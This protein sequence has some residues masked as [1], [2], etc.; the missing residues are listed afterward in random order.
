MQM[1]IPD[2]MKVPDKMKKPMVI[3]LVA[4]VILFGGI[5]IYKVFINLMMKRFF[6]TQKN[7]TYTVSTTAANYAIWKPQIS[8]VGSTRAT[9]GVNVTAQIGGMIQKIYFTPGAI[10]DA[11]DTL[12]QQNADPNIGQLHSLQANAE[13]ARITYERDK[14]Q[15][16]ANGISKQQLDSDLQNWK[17][18]QGQVEQQQ[19]IVQQLTITAPFKGKLGVSNVNPGQFLNPGDTVVTLQSLDPIYVDFYLPQNQLSYVAINQDVDI[20]IDAF[21]G[22]KFTGKITTINPIV[23]KNTRNVQVEATV[24]NPENLL[25]PGMFTTV[26]V[27]RDIQEKLITLPRAAV[28]FNPYGDLVYRVVKSGTDKKGKEILKVKQKFVTVG[29]SRGDQVS[30]LSGVNEGDEIVTG[31]QLKLKNN[32]FVAINNTVQPS[33]NPDPKVTNEHNGK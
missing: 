9:L 10:V 15:F 6:A 27:N 33:E 3:M 11:N 22:K 32:S 30:I 19:A 17:S 18:Y 8:A 29:M 4:L 25:L 1:K 5:F 24:P 2:R 23:D 26:E 14:K 20:A 31:G 7:P 21:P 13:L 12:V 28:T 16:K